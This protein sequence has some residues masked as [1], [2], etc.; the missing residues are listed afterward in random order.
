[1][2]TNSVTRRLG[3]YVSAVLALMTLMFGSLGSGTAIAAPALHPVALAKVVDARGVQPPGCNPPSLAN[4]YTEATMQPYIDKVLPMIDQFF[5]TQY[6]AMPTPGRYYFV[7]VGQHL[8]GA[9]RGTI[10]DQAYEYCSSDH[11]VYLGQAAMWR[12][13]SQDG[14]IAPAV[15]LAHEWGHNVQS[16]V[17]VPEPQTN[18]ESINHENQADC[19]AGAW[20]QYAGQPAQNWLEAE[21][22]PHVP[23]LVRAI[24][25]AEDDP[26]RDHGTLQQRASSM[27]RG[28]QGGLAAC[29]D[30]YPDTPVYVPH[31]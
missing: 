16:Q 31:S 20:I 21:D 13:Y 11:N 19:I 18:D 2:K 25:S 28:M 10:T 22:V 7:S 30:F 4:C 1:L 24:A 9:C 5:R 23:D 29:N 3:N 12:Y 15:G 6:A 8:Q 26:N 27:L 14:D 17:G